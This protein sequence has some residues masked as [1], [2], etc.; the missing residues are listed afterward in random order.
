MFGLLIDGVVGGGGRTIQGKEAPKVMV[1]LNAF[2]KLIASPL[3]LIQCFFCFFTI[4]FKN[5]SLYV[6]IINK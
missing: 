3:A 5:I 6:D 4:I 2:G 1:A